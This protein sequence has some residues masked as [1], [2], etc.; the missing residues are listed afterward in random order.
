MF[1]R[2]F[3]SDILTHDELLAE[4]GL[5]AHTIRKI[6]AEADGEVGEFIRV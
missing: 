2:D 1:E 3:D 4:I 5:D 6:R